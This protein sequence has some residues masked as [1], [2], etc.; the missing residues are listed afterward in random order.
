MKNELFN[1]CHIKWYRGMRICPHCSVIQVT[2]QRG[3]DANDNLVPEDLYRVIKPV[4]L[5]LRINSHNHGKFM[6]CPNWPNCNYNVSFGRSKKN[7]WI[8]DNRH[9]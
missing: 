7:Y 6:G 2:I 8:Y 1:T 5:V 9:W 3:I 4:Y